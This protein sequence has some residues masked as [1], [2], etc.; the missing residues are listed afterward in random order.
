MEAKSPERPPIS[1]EDNLGIVDY[2]NFALIADRVLDYFKKEPDTSVCLLFTTMATQLDFQ[3]FI[4]NNDGYTR[5]LLLEDQEK[6]LI[7]TVT[8]C[9]GIEGEHSILYFQHYNRPGTMWFFRANAGAYKRLNVS[10]TRQ[11]QSIELLMADSKSSWIMCD[12]L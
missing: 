8:N 11:R 6:L 2:D 12:C 3:S 4:S 9:Q 7:S 5:L 10:I 1:I